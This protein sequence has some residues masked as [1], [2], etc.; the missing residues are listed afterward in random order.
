MQRTQ[1]DA[2]G[3]RAPL[4]KL[5]VYKVTGLSTKKVPCNAS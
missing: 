2:M 3:L 1:S 4:L 5:F